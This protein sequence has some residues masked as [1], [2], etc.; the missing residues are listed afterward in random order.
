M[1]FSLCL[2]SNFAART[3]DEHAQEGKIFFFSRI[4]DRCAASVSSDR[5]T[6]S[7]VGCIPCVVL[8]VVGQ[9]ACSSFISEE[10]HMEELHFYLLI[11]CVL[12]LHSF[13]MFFFIDLIVDCL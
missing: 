11:V 2:L 12:I 7:V 9:A 5:H 10:D 8:F 3:R 13:S 4:M 1:I 6:S